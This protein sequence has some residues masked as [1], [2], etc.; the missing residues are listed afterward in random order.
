MLIIIVDQYF[1]LSFFP[2]LQMGLKPQVQNGLG[3][4]HLG[5]Q[6]GFLKT[7][8][9]T[10]PQCLTKK[11]TRVTE[12]FLVGSSLSCHKIFLVG[13]WWIGVCRKPTNPSN[14]TW[15]NPTRQVGS[16]FKAWWVGLGYKYFFNSGSGWVWVIKLQTC[17]TLPDPPIFN[18]YLEYII[19]LI[20]IF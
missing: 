12:L 11:K 18:I 15:F 20:Y 16:V 13:L 2:Q 17:Q 9:Q 1:F 6:M 8:F 7:R 4:A 19:Y 5:W 10:R 3:E 14:P